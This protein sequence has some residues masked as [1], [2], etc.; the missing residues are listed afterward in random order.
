MALLYL[1]L[2]V[3]LSGCAPVITTIYKIPDTSDALAAYRQCMAVSRPENFQPCL[4]GIPGVNKSPMST[5][6]GQWMWNGVSWVKK[7]SSQVVTQLDASNSCRI[8]A[9]YNDAQGNELIIQACTEPGTNSPLTDSPS[10]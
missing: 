1:P 7:N 4:A 8:L 3:V 9:D 10:K 6:E 2:I 5:P